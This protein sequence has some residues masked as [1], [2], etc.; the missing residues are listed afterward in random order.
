M[1]END[2]HVDYVVLGVFNKH[3]NKWFL[4]DQT[5]KPELQKALACVKSPARIH[6]RRIELDEDVDAHKLVVLSNGIDPSSLCKQIVAT[7]VLVVKGKL[8]AL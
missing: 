2:D 3:Y 8:V 7:D 4:M 5:D 6:L 1:D